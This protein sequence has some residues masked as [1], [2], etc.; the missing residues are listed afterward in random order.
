M[1]GRPPSRFIGSQG[2][3]LQGPEGQHG[4]AHCVCCTMFAEQR[5]SCTRNSIRISAWSE[6]HFRPV[7]AEC[8]RTGFSP[9]KRQLKLLGLS[10]R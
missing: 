1:A 10:G 7:A 8:W 3:E 4:S 6:Q 9:H 2:R 5:L